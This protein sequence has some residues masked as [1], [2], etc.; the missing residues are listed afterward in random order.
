MRDIDVNEWRDPAIAL[1]RLVKADGIYTFYY[2]ETNNIRRLHVTAEGLN[3][4]EPMCF[5]LGGVAHRG[6]PRPLDV[7]GLKAAVRLQASAHELKLA[8]LGKGDFLGLLKSWRVEAYLDW[9]KAEALLIH[10]SA[11]DPLYWSTVDIV[12]SIISHEPLAHMQRFHLKLKADLF[13]ILAAD[14]DDIADLFH[15]FSYPDVGEA[16]RAAF[17]EEL[18]QRL[19]DREGLLSEFDGQMLKGVLQAGRGRDPLIYLEDEPPNT[20]LDSF[21]EFFIHRICLF[22]H[23]HHL[24]DVE[25]VIQ[26]RLRACAFHDDGRVLDTYRFVDS[27]VEP[28]IQASDALVGLLGKMFSYVTRTDRAQLIADR[29]ALTPGQTRTLAKLNALLDR[30]DAETPALLHQVASVSAMRAGQFFLQGH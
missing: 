24:L 4:R 9:L 13:T 21:V 14:I 29:R 8:H 27:R 6:P 3:V 1:N 5:V 16:S 15:R 26:D 11:V 20:L 10:Y 17:I 25:P 7:A 22:K 23:A 2:D 12:D 28:G 18:L 19:D 30:S